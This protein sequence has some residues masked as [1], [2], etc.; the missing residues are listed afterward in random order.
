MFEESP[1]W[2]KKKA[3]F[4][5]DLGTA[6][7]LVV[8]R[9]GGVVFEQPSVCCF[10]EGVGSGDELFAAGAVARSIVGREVRRMR[11]VRPL[12]N[13][14]LADVRATCELL[15]FAVGPFQSRQRLRRSRVIIGV[16][17]DATQAERRALTKAAHDAGLAEPM[18]VAEPM[19]AAIGCGLDVS[20][21]RG[22]M[23]VDCGA[24]TTD[25]VVLSLGKICVARS[26][27]GGGDAVDAALLQH[28]HL[29]RQFNIGPSSA[30]AL[31]VALSEALISSTQRHVEV[32]GLD[33]KSGLPRVLALDIAELRPIIE[34]HADEVAAAVRSAFAATAP[35]LASG[36]FEDGITLTGGAA[37]TALV[38]DRIAR[39]TGLEVMCGAEPNKAVARGLEVM[40]G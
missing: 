18:L 19:L 36:I 37:L 9:S 14:V 29:K 22:R 3:D 11:T 27:R 13:G 16:P 10:N 12:R 2:A 8:Q 32:K 39:S 23:V 1:H 15:K 38:A 31:K 40:L 25:V 4:A 7:T 5:I 24:G 28:L 30:E 17:T 34:K 35:D 26:V 33:I 20:E 6:N 21:A